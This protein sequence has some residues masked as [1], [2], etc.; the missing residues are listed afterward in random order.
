MCATCP[1]ALGCRR[2]ERSGN[3]LQLLAAAAKGR[4]RSKEAS[5]AT[6]VRVAHEVAEG[7]ACLHSHGILHSDLKVR[8][9]LIWHTC[10]TPKMAH[11]PTP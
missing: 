8:P 10:P 3:L 1:H 11:V 9:A 5:V 7:L 2:A 4:G 6:R